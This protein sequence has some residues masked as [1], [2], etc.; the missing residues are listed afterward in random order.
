M[1]PNATNMSREGSKTISSALSAISNM[2]L[3]SFVEP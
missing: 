2:G 1:T 3:L